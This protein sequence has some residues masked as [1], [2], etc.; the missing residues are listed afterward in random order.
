MQARVTSPDHRRPR[1]IGP[2][3]ARGLM[4]L[5]I[6]I[7]NVV[8]GWVSGG[9]VEATQRALATMPEPLVTAV[10]VFEAVF[11]HVR[12][13]PMFSTLLGFGVGLIVA[14][15][16]R[17]Y[18]TAGQIRD[19][20]L[21]RYALLAC[22]GVVHA[23]LLFYGDIL[24][25]YGLAGMLLALLA[26][27]KTRTLLVIAAVIAAVWTSCF[28]LLSL[29]WPNAVGATFTAE[30]SVPRSYLEQVVLGMGQAVAGPLLFPV[31]GCM[32]LP[33]MILGFLAARHRVL[34]RLKD[35]KHLVWAAIAVASV[36]MV[37]VGVPLGLSTV[38]AAA[39]AA[40]DTYGRWEGLNQ[41]FGPLTGP[42]VVAMIAVVGQRCQQQRWI[43]PLAALGKRSMSGYVAQSVIFG[44][45][46]ASY[47]L[48]WGN[49]AN[50]LTMLALAFAG[51]GVTLL[52]A[53][54]CERANQP[55][56]LEQ[57]HRRLAYGTPGVIKTGPE[58]LQSQ[59]ACERTAAIDGRAFP[60]GG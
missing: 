2:D 10:A 56:P 59:R 44:A 5:G 24:V 29:V 18:R 33:P 1:L 49:G 37:G 50:L 46:V 22:F 35:C 25:F 23:C 14:S 21:R 13:L 38:R 34:S 12:G 30:S 45:L 40:P 6:A 16:Q 11:V 54:W 60:G 53:W 51:W 43:R 20:L 32:L 58:L 19:L 26:P 27:L 4:L 41:A 3:L 36:V 15:E 42:G 55:G 31:T 47:G 52:G 57:L 8:T 48:G 7:A 28:A 9:A 17:R 39:G